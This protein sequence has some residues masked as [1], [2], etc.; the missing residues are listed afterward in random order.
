MSKQLSTGQYLGATIGRAE[1]PGVV[2]SE[3]RHATR[4]ALPA[5][6]HESCYLSLLV[7]GHYVERIG[8]ARFDYRP[9]A[10]GFHP[11]GL[12][13]HDEVGVDGATFFLLAISPEWA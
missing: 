3:V 5:H 4:R 10:I 9:F 1:Y 2:L 6:S 7:D 13:H 11:A 8:R 12:F